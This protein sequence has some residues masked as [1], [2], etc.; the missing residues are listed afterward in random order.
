MARYIYGN[1]ARE[2]EAPVR[3]PRQRTEHNEE[4]RRQREQDLRLEEN[5]ER[6]TRIGALFTLFIAAATAVMLF[7]GVK[8]I[9][10][11]NQNSDNSTKIVKLQEQVQNM[12]EAND[13]REVSIDTS[14]DYDYIYNIATKE[15]GMVFADPEQIV[16]YKSGESE[17]VMQF[18]NIPEN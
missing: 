15:L 13:Q 5:R 12:K 1:A 17:Y 11:I 10:L 18:S 7:A 4:I 2:L 16:N 3:V 6:A 8:Y 14:K 9:R